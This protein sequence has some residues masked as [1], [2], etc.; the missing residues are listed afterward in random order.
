MAFMPGQQIHEELSRLVST[1]QTELLRFCYAYLH[2]QALAEDAVQDTFLKA[3]RTLDRFRADSSE[4][5]WLM[6]IAVNTCRD[7]RRSAWFRYVNRA[8]TPDM[9]PEPSEPTA[10]RDLEVT[11]EIMSLPIKLREAILLYYY[12]NVS[13]DEMAAILGITQQGASA[14]LKRAREKLRP[15][16]ERRREDE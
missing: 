15:I 14:R 13:I 12:Q 9:L 16:L 2:D 6:K 1:Y 11:A 5:T 3:Y 8:I 4:K 10:Y 7:V